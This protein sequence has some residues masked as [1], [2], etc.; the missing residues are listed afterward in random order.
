MSRQKSRGIVENVLSGIKADLKAI[1]N[2]EHLIERKKMENQKSKSTFSAILLTLT[3]MVAALGVGLAIAAEKKYVTDPTTGKVVSS[4]EYGGTLTSRRGP[5][6]QGTDPYYGWTE[7]KNSVVN[8]K[9]GIGNWGIDRE[10]WNF[11][12]VFLPVSFMTGRLAESWDISPDGLTYTFHI[13][14][15]VHWHNKAPMNGRE[16]TA[17]DVEY[18][19][20]RM[21]GMGKFAD[22]G[23]NAW[24]GASDFV[25]IPWE[26]VTTTD[27][28]TMVVKLT[29]PYLSALGLML[30]G[31]V[32]YIMPPEVIEQHGDVMDW[33]NL[34]GT[35]PFMLTD[36]V[37]DSS[38]TFTKNPDYW[39]YDEKYPQNRLPYVDEFKVLTIEDEATV[40]AALR[41]GKLDY[42]RWAPD[43]DSV[44]SLKRTNPE[45]VA[46][47]ILFWSN[48]AF[49]PNHRVP[50][51]NDINVVRAMQMAL[52][53]EIAAATYW[54][55][56]ADATPMGLQGVK[57][58]Y[59][60]FEE[61]D[62]EV[63]QYYRYDPEG[64]EKLLDEAGY[65]RGADGTRFKTVL[66][67]GSF[68]S[69]EFAEI[70]AAYW[71]EIGVD[72]DIDALSYAE[73]QERVY[74]R[75]GEGMYMAIGGSLLDPVR[76]T[77]WY[78]SDD[79]GNRGGSQ[80]PELD[81]MVDAVLD[82]TTIEEQK[83]PIAEADKYVMSRH[84]LIWGPRS[85]TFRLVQPWV[86]GYNGEFDQGLDAGVHT[87]FARLWIDSELKEAMG[88]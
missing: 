29:K 19:F 88:H 80:W 39:G 30:I 35:G 71:A 20:H 41:S 79:R 8:D 60:P 13:R 25:N 4:P 57:G 61:W 67:T 78:H 62:E 27:K 40:M 69:L 86:K 42:R 10:V 73:Y 26:S 58:Y 55:G 17:E 52:D 3:L 53:N 38:Y 87:I 1:L 59:I 31:R 50:P 75:T 68:A 34:V 21:L 48:N 22:A 9:L 2:F 83:R 63:K 74:S 76:M 70:A 14:P 16:L 24:G 77:T 36:V 18:N 56:Q 15:G 54:K 5:P 7:I 82:A 66:N 49:A 6:V 47:P 51:F 44:L 33:R 84:W 85:P 28:Y 23:P 65:K 43:L 72:V 11:K 64:A 45:I 81:A 37:E 32:N 46:H 12:S